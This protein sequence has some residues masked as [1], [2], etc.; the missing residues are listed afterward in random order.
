MCNL[1]EVTSFRENTLTG[2]H[3]NLLLWFTEHHQCITNLSSLFRR[4]SHSLWCGGW[5][6]GSR[7]VAGVFAG[8]LQPCEIEVSVNLLCKGQSAY[9]LA[10]SKLHEATPS[11]S[12]ANLCFPSGSLADSTI[13]LRIDMLLTHRHAHTVGLIFSP[14]SPSR[15]VNYW[16]NSTR[17]S[18]SNS[19]TAWDSA[20]VICSKEHLIIC[21]KDEETAMYLLTSMI[22]QCR[23]RVR[24]RKP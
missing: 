11:N 18:S 3:C 20:I 19:V 15:L 24:F 13:S 16:I 6:T 23:P 4:P 22:F 10:Q 14:N 21:L 8:P 5:R 12:R 1:I 2:R 7:V 9:I 17:S